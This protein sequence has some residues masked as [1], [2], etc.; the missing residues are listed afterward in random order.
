MTFKP[1]GFLPG[2]TVQP[3][4]IRY[5]VTG[6]LELYSIRFLSSSCFSKK[7]VTYT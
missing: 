5:K 1:G 3:V 7:Y 6:L 2:K 4:L